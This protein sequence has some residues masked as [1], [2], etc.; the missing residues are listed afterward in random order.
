[1]I[2]VG[3]GALRRQSHATTVA[4]SL[5]ADYSRRWARSRTAIHQA[6]PAATEEEVGLLFVEYQY[7]EK[8][9]RQVRAYLA[10]R[11]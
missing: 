9:A 8:L 6:H 7:G 3:T 4:S 2:R 5:P 1:M 11:P 10:S